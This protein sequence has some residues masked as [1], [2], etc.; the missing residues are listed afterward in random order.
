MR[1]IYSKIGN[2]SVDGR[3]IGLLNIRKERDE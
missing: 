2:M 1:Q 3:M